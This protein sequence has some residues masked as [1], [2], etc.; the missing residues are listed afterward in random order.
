MKNNKGFTLIELLAVITIMG[1]L[2]MVAIPT[3]SRTIENSRKDTF[4]DTAKK[5]SDSVRTLWSGDNFSCTVAGGGNYNSSAV[6]VGTYYVRIDTT[7]SSAPVLLE[8]GGKSSW[9]SRHVKGYVK[10]VVDAK[11]YLYGDANL[12]GIIN[13][14]DASA[15]LRYDNGTL[16][17]NA[18]QLK[19]S[20][21]NGDGSVDNLDSSL[22]VQK[23]VGGS[24]NFVAIDYYQQSIEFY[25]VMSDD[26]H[27]VNLNDNPNIVTSE[28]LSRGDL[29]MADATYDKAAM[30]AAALVCVER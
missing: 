3:V 8:Q 30:P 26:I 29:V 2:M 15:I 20:D 27:G 22:I 14:S 17:F 1:I 16:E 5:Y 11:R 25:T 4:L 12:D 21:V 19:I 9:G 7:D 10:V 23:L 24:V 18:L 28:E 13:P 6:P